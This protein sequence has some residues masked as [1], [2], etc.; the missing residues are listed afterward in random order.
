MQSRTILKKAA[1]LIVLVFLPGIFALSKPAFAQ[2]AS[3]PK[4]LIT[5]QT[6]GSYIPSFYVGKALPTYGSKITASLELLSPQ[7]KTINLSGQT[8][9]WYLNDNLIGGGTGTQQVTFSPTGQ[10]PN[11]LNLRVTLPSYNGVYLIHAITIPMV[12]PEATIDAPYPAGQFS[13]NPLDL[14]A[15]PFFFNIADPSNLSYAWSVNGQS[16]SNTENPETAQ[17]TLP[18]GTQSGTAITVSLS[19]KNPND[20]TIATAG[21]TLTY[22]NQ[23]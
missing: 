6:T 4:F 14:Q 10:A 21:A 7:G 2:T 9:Y 18:T 12:L 19:I 5:W 11:S 8:I 13:Q 1:V 17:V 22:Q 23:L 16:G 20:S 3:S 15:I